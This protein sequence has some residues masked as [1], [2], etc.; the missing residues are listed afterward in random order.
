MFPIPVGVSPAL[1]TWVLPAGGAAAATAPATSLIF[2]RLAV[3]AAAFGATPIMLVRR[4]FVAS[5]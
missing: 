2:V 5:S 1:L 3:A 4:L